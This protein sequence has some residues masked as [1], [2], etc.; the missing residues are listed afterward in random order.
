MSRV[1]PPD[2]TTRVLFAS[3]YIAKQLKT[4]Y[5]SLNNKNSVPYDTHNV[6]TAM[7]HE[8][9]VQTFGRQFV[10]RMLSRYGH[11]R[12]LFPTPHRQE[13]NRLFAVLHGDHGSVVKRGINI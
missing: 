1:W 4:M 12:E 3:T 11:Q 5:Y 9:N 13:L 10:Q 6:I 2:G 8:L 7:P